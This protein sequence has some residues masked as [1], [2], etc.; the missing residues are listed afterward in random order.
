MPYSYTANVPQGTQKISATQSPINANFQAINELVNIDHLTFNTGAEIGKHK[1]TT[2]PAQAA[3]PA[4]LAGEEGLYNLSYTP[5]ASAAKN[6][7][8]VHKQTLAGTADIPFTASVLSNTAPT[9]GMQG[10]SYLPSGLL[11]KWTGVAGTGL[12]TFT[13]P[14]AAPTFTKIFAIYLTPYNGSTG[15][16][17]FAIRLVDVVSMTQFRVY[18]SAR[19]TAGAAAGAANALIIGV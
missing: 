3:A 12:T 8:Y 5:P 7:L 17:D 11:I 15:D 19:T 9:D 18:F 16:V 6:E 10:W 14:A 13:F 1:K 2:F 4:F